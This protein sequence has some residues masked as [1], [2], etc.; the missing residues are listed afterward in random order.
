MGHEITTAALGY[1]I[2]IIWVVVLVAGYSF[3]SGLRIVAKRVSVLEKENLQL[4]K[5]LA[6]VLKFSSAVDSEAD[7]RSGRDAELESSIEGIHQRLLTLE[8]KQP[9]IAPRPTRMNFRQ[10]RDA[11]ERSTEIPEDKES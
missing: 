5:G 1:A 6:S 4:A 11:V 9:K 3:H 7:I 2:T 8:N 10:F